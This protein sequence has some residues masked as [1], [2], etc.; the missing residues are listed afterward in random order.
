M[1][2]ALIAAPASVDDVPHPHRQGEA[3][4]SELIRGSE[5]L[6]SPLIDFRAGWEY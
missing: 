1:R 5:A 4:G 3:E 6:L 2:P